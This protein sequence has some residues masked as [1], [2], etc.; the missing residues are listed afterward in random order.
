[1]YDV[2]GVL[3]HMHSLTPTPSKNIQA[4]SNVV[5]TSKLGVEQLLWD[6][7]EH[8]DK[9]WSIKNRRAGYGSQFIPVHM[10]AYFETHSAH[11]V[12]MASRST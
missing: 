8:I 9:V 10:R 12:R 3:I 4:N 1:M 5:D 6:E 11:G 7:M 2:S